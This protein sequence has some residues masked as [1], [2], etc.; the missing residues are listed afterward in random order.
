MR[1]IIKPLSLKLYIRI[2]H[3]KQMSAF[4][5]C[6]RIPITSVSTELAKACG[7]PKDAEG[8]TSDTE[9]NRE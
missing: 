9:A 1:K 5:D 2:V 3:D 7:L 4:F 8:V 6:D